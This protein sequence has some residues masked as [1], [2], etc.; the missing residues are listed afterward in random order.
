M[1]PDAT[2][3]LLAGG[4]MLAALV[5]LVA[6]LRRIEGDARS[7]CAAATGFVALGGVSTVLLGLGI[8][9]VPVGDAVVEVPSVAEDLVTYAGIFAMIALMAGASRRLVAAVVA[10]IAV[11]RIA[12]ELPNAGFVEGTGALAA[13]GVV[14]VGY[15]VVIGLF[16]GPI[17]RA[18]ESVSPRRRLLFWKLRNLALFLIGALIAYAVLAVSGALDRFVGTVANLHLDIL[19]RLGVAAFVFANA[20]A[21]VDDADGDAAAGDHGEAAAS[22]SDGSAAASAGDAAAGGA[23]A[24]D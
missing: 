22:A 7:Y 24:D 10:V 9:V 13:A 6:W 14:V 5:P 12:F 15:A 1:I 21:L 18:A 20:D 3:D 16:L 8:G 19:L 17:S 4:S 23:A 11:Q 2:L